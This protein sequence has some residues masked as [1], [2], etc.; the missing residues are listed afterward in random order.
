M[1]KIKYILI[2]CLALLILFSCNKEDDNFDYLD[3]ATAPANVSA[4][5]QITQDN[6]GV[7]TITPNGEGAVSYNIT[8]GDGTAESVIVKQGANT[9]HVYAE[10][11]YTVK[12]EATGITGLKSEVEKELIVSFRAPENLEVNA[13]IDSSNP[14]VL[15]VSATAD[16]AT[17]FLVYFDTS[18]PDEE[19][20][21]LDNGASVS[22]EYPAVGDYTIKV[23][24]LSGGVSTTEKTEVITIAKP[25][26]LPIDFEI[27]DASAFIGF[28]GASAAVVDN[29]DTN[30]NTSSKVGKIVKGGPETWA[31][32]VITTSA[33]IDFSTKKFIKMKVWS[34]RAGGK[35]ILKLENLTD[36]SINKEV[37]VTTVGN[38]AWEEVVFDLST[39]DVSKTYQKLVMFF[40]IGTIGTGG[41][42]WT[43]YIDDIKQFDGVTGPSIFPINFE[44]PYQLSSFDGGDISVITNP[45]TTGNSSGMVS[46]LVKNAGQ[47]WAGSKI[48]VDTPFSIDN[49]TTVTAKVW[50]PRVGLNLLMKFEDAT[51]WP[52]TKATNE[53]TATTTKANAWEELTFTLTGVDAA[54]DYVNLVLI[55]DNGTSGDGSANYTIYVDDISVVSFLDFEPQQALSSFDG[56]AI[57]VIANPYTTGNSSSMVAK[58]VKDAGQVWAGSKITVTTPFPIDNSTTIT[59]KVW[60]PR[61]GLNLLMKFEDATGWPNTKATNEITATT[62]KANAWEELSFTLTGVDAAVDYV[63]L[64]LIMDNGTAGDGSANYTIYIDDIQN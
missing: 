45:Q 21:H 1:K 26:E 30:G 12:I 18:N 19:P 10:G 63:N 16:Y 20:T 51:G 9:Q 37:E 27:F 24:A 33:P 46:K 38:G 8:Y 14:F 13:E 52:N 15:K 58:L 5:F 36:G 53:I 50:S 57:S 17:Y 6:T 25:T 42:N 59:A 44:A 2:N 55:M 43:F 29:P 28:G 56:G 3:S 48:T 41:A 47:V 40:D 54:V 49:S 61:V 23:V 34:P 60:S 7:V 31:G 64:V 32:N 11:S 4:S 62:T 39:I 22:F 35:M